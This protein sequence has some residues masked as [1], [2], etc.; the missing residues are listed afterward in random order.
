MTRKLVDRALLALFIVMAVLLYNSTASYT[1]IA[2]KTS[3]KYVQFLAVSI[4]IL[5]AIQLGFSILRNPDTGKLVLSENMF[6]FVGLL[7]GLILFAMS[8]EHFGFF[9][10]ALIFIPVIAVLLG[11]R[12]YVTI[13][14]TTIGVLLFVYLVFIK[15]L[16]VNLPGFNF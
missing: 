6:K 11:Y 12:N 3:A 13:A 1:G 8:F 7:I 14:A 16:S 2:L 15:L 9:I 5:S 4:G 10:P